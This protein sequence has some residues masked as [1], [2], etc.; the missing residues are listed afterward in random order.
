MA[1]RSHSP[2]LWRTIAQPLQVWYGIW[3]PLE[4][5]EFSV[6]N[7]VPFQCNL[8]AFAIGET[9]PKCITSSE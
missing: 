9:A 7:Q 5:Q 6:L 4:P 3:S 8:S 2:I 1:G